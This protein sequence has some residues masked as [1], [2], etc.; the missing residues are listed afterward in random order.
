MGESGDN[1]R[2]MYWSKED[3]PIPKKGQVLRT[4]LM[5]VT[6]LSAPSNNPKMLK[7]RFK[8]W[9]NEQ[10]PDGEAETI[11]PTVRRNERVYYLSRRA[12]ENLHRCRIIVERIITGDIDINSDMGR[13]ETTVTDQRRAGAKPAHGVVI[14]GQIPVHN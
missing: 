14:S 4:C 5:S 10:S 7:L 12:G 3:T 11:Q 13:Q 8:G 9:N 2:D 1:I 6:K